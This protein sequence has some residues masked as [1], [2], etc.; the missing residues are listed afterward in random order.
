MPGIFPTEPK[1][2]FTTFCLRDHESILSDASSRSQ[3]QMRRQEWH[4]MSQTGVL[5]L[6]MSMTAAALRRAVQ[7]FDV[8]LGFVHGAFLRGGNK[9]ATREARPL[10]CSATAKSGPAAEASEAEGF[11]KPL[12]T[13]LPPFPPHSDKAR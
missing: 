5:P 12:H 3:S 1:I 6:R 10:E 11:G 13:S 2:D 4:L 8:Y 7:T 9:R